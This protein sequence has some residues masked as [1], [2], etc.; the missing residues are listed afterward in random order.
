M[1]L[2]FQPLTRRTFLSASALAS[3]AI[4]APAAAMALNAR[5]LAL[6]SSHQALPASW[7]GPALVLSGD[8]LARLGQLR[9]A[10]ESHAPASC[11]LF[12]DDADRVLFDVAAHAPH[13]KGFAA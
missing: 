2:P 4:A 3:A 9:Q 5:P 12:L 10:L 13:A 7:Q 6:A 8:Y 11:R 1:E